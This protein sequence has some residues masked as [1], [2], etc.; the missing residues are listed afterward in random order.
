MKIPFVVADV[1][2]NIV[3]VADLTDRGC[4]VVLDDR[5]RITQGSNV[6][7][8]MRQ[9]NKFLLP[10]RFPRGVWG[11]LVADVAGETVA[12]K[13]LPK[14][15]S[16]EKVAEH[17]R[18]HIPSEPW[19]RC[20]VLGRARD[21]A[22]RRQHERE[23]ACTPTV[24][25]DY[26]FLSL[27][28]P[29]AEAATVLAMVDTRTGMMAGTLVRE[30]GPDTFSVEAVLS[31]VNELG[32]LNFQIQTDGEPAVTALAEAVKQNLAAKSGV[33]QV[34]LRRSPPGSHASNGAEDQP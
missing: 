9:G 7:E 21:E 13:P 32:Y 12:G 24:A 31:F 30:K 15:P 26:G 33:Q 16:D 22:H 2:T 27:A 19:C 1:A 11:E 3:A 8:L 4:A 29:D 17:V 34:T 14:R 18:T 10:M 6:I 23:T 5:P 20:C 28:E 25:M